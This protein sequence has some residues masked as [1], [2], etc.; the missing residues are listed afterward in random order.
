MIYIHLIGHCGEKGNISAK[1][2]P[3]EGAGGVIIYSN[4]VDPFE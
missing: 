1:K 2:T 3:S 4:Y